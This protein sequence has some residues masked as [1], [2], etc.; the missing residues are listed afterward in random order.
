MSIEAVKDVY[1]CDG[2]QDTFAVT[3]E[4]AKTTDVSAFVENTTTGERRR[5]VRNLDYRIE[6]G[7]LIL[8][9]DDFREPWPTGWNLCIIRRTRF[10]QGSS[11]QMTPYV[12]ALRINQLTQLFEQIRE[13]T[14]RTLHTGTEYPALNLTSARYAYEFDEAM[15]HFSATLIGGFLWTNPLPETLQF[16]GATLTGGDI[17]G[18]GVSYT[19]GIPEAVDLLGAV[20]LGGD[21]WGT[22]VE[23][24]AGAHD[25]DLLGAILLGGDIAETAK[26]VEYTLWPAEG[27]DLSG[28]ILTG[29]DLT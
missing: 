8:R 19:V 4:F 20:V 9:N 13:Q 17:F 16:N 22:G 1:P 23:Y 3:F 18:G 7:N 25:V 14:L 28:A 29:G 5:L 10:E 15:Q 12:F 24:D 2:V 26:Y 21:I 11:Q 27:V 6:N